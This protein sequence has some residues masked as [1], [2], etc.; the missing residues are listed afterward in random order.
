MIVVYFCGVGPSGLEIEK[1][2][3]LIPTEQGKAVGE[4]FVRFNSSETAEKALGNHMKTIGKRSQPPCLDG[5]LLT[6]LLPPSGEAPG[7]W[8]DLGGSFAPCVFILGR[9]TEQRP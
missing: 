4:A 1:D 6:I 8:L 7:P 3:I 5:G 9:K 2:G